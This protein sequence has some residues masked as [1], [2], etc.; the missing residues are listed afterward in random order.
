MRVGNGAAFHFPPPSLRIRFAGAPATMRTPLQA[1]VRL[2]ALMSFW[3]VA[4][5]ADL[6]TD[7]VAHWPLDVME[8]TRTPDLVGGYDLEVE[9]SPRRQIA[10][11]RSARRCCV[12]STRRRN[13]CRPIGTR[14]SRWPS[15][16]RRRLGQKYRS[17]TAK[18]RRAAAPRPSFWARMWVHRSTTTSGTTA[19]RRAA[20]N[21][22]RKDVFDDT[23]HHVAWVHA[24]GVA[25][26]FVEMDWRIQRPGIRASR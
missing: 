10:S 5:G 12:A 19:A 6:S 21:F 13:R 16:R 23:W 15:G 11:I 7:L 24:A 17:F 25:T 3:A 20:I 2:Y 8:G 14:T 18:D 1:L 9:T 4:P 26:L 22:P